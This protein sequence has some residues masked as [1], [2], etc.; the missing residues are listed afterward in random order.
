MQLQKKASSNYDH[1]FFDLDHTLWDFEANSKTALQI[2]FDN[3]LQNRD[4]T[5][6]TFFSSYKEVNDFCWKQY[7]TGNMGKEELR[8]KRFADTFLK[9]GFKDDK[10][11]NQFAD[12]YL[13]I[14][15]YQTQLMPGT[16][17]LLGSLKNKGYPLHI[18]TNGFEEVQTIKIRECGLNPYFDE[19]I[20]SEQLKHNKPHPSVFRFAIEKV[21]TTAETSL[22]IG[23]NLE[24]DILGAKGV[25]MDGVYFNPKN[26]DHHEEVKF[27]V[28]SLSEI[29]FI[30]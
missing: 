30:L 15:P 2:L 17:S 21:K 20:I 3:N 11:S 29:E 27:E 19:I 8:V 9:F 7:R 6:D 5:F 18:I 10:L 22:M 28:K 26:I 25:G 13:E 12:Q 14:S 4:F 16:I 24:V 1:I 23:D